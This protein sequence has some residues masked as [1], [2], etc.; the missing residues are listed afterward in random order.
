MSVC[1]CICDQVHVSETVWDVCVCACVC[2]FQVDCFN[3]LINELCVCRLE[4]SE[5]PEILWFCE[6]AEHSNQE[7]TCYP[8][9]PANVRP[10]S[11]PVCLLLRLVDAGTFQLYQTLETQMSA[12]QRQPPHFLHKTQ[13][14]NAIK[15]KAKTECISAATRSA[16][17][18]KVLNCEEGGQKWCGRRGN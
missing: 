18:R 13:K 7:P 15:K 9:T 3:S 10:N 1:V 6:R 11:Q 16:A 2:V 8:G 14:M 12:L 4:D 5:E 17:H